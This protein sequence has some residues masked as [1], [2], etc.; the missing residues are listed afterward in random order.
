LIGTGGLVAGVA[1]EESAE[2]QRATQR[3][4]REVDMTVK[5]DLEWPEI[6]EATAI[7]EA[8]INNSANS[9]FFRYR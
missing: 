4:T 6:D 5:C 1:T 7:T 9:R 2:K 8:D 3:R